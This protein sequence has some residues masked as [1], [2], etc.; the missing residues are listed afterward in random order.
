MSKETK[1]ALTRKPVLS[2]GP[3]NKGASEERELFE[4]VVG[5]NTH[6]QHPEVYYN[7]LGDKNK[8]FG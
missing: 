3:Q 1:D 4:K 8:N 6:K 7:V 2:A 5:T